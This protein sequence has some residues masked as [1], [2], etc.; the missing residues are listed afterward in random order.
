MDFDFQ[1]DGDQ[2]SEESMLDSNFDDPI[3]DEGK[4]S[5]INSMSQT[6]L[7]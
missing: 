2:V 1:D 3:D 4:E 5:K 7:L 6:I